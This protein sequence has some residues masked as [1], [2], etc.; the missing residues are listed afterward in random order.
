MQG[1]VDMLVITKTKTGSTFLLNQLTD[2]NYLKPYRF[3][4]KRNGGGVFIYVQYSK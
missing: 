4:G 1:K 2:Y 3:D